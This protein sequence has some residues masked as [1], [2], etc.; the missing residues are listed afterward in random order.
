MQ[1]LQF[2]L[3]VHYFYTPLL[4]GQFSQQPQVQVQV[5][6]VMLSFLP[7]ADF[8]AALQHPQLHLQTKI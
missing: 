1:S 7:D 5:G 2:L 4:L 8:G 3:Q 6:L